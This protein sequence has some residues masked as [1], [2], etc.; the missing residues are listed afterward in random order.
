MDI[1]EKKETTPRENVSVFYSA[2]REGGNYLPSGRKDLPSIAPFYTGAELNS[3]LSTG[4]IA[5]KRS[6]SRSFYN[7]NGIY[8]RILSF[9]ATVI[10]YNFLVIPHLALK[11]TYKEEFTNKN[12]HAALAFLEGSEFKKWYANWALK[13]LVDGAYFGAINRL[14]KKRVLFVDLPIA[15]C[16]STAKDF[17]GNDIV[18][19]NLTY[20]STIINEKVRN[21]VLNSYPEEIVDAYRAYRA[22]KITDAWFRLSPGVGF[23]FTLVDGVPPFLST[24]D[25]LNDYQESVDLELERT[26][27]EIQKVL[28]QKVPHLNTGDLVF[29]PNEAAVMHDGTVRMLSKNKNI[30]VLTTYADVDVVTSRNQS[31]A[32]KTSALN[33]MAQNI[34][35]E[36]GISGQLFSTQN[37]QALKFNIDAAISY[38]MLLVN[39]FSRFTTLLVN[40]VFERTQMSFKV[41]ILPVGQLNRSVYMADA[42]KL[43]SSGYS[44]LLPAVAMG[45]SQRDIISLK[46][47]EN[48]LLKLEEK[49]I[50][51]STSWTQSANGGTGG[52][53][54]KSLEEKAEKTVTNVEK[55]NREEGSA[56][57]N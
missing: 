43:A 28:V 37:S 9:Y 2:L 39:Q 16:R 38:M 25:A 23:Y 52:R 14:D 27:E 5:Q 53:P 33:A 31:E 30:A 6:L 19:F 1:E 46:D 12:Y 24:I 4:S 26:K 50:P 35:Q 51:L 10:E 18:E 21:K 20:F 54:E 41:E 36:A 49:F 56:K 34:F 40:K 17:Y 11:T 44:F 8:H 3:V 13:V 22:G 45:I 47:L 15:Y 32:S 48:D 29:E 55:V 42:L 7:T 57:T